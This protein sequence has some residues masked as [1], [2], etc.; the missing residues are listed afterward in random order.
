MLY[1]KRI[2]IVCKYSSVAHKLIDPLWVKGK[3]PGKGRI[4]FCL[5]KTNPETQVFACWKVFLYISEN[6]EYNPIQLLC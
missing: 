3:M 6:Y 5:F 4:R 1:L 2:F